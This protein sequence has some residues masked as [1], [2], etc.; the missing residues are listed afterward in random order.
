MKT[1]RIV[2]AL[3]I[4][5]T[6]A[7]A[8]TRDRDARGDAHVRDGSGREAKR[9]GGVRQDDL[10]DGAR[11]RFRARDANGREVVREGVVSS[12]R[13]RAGRTAIVTDGGHHWEF[14]EGGRCY[15]PWSPPDLPIYAIVET[16]VY[17]GPPTRLEMYMGI[18]AMLGL[19]VGLLVAASGSNRP[20]V[21][22]CDV[23]DPNHPCSST[24]SSGG[25]EIAAIAF[26]LLGI[27]LGGLIGLSN[28][29]ESAW[30]PIRMA[31][32][33]KRGEQSFLTLSARF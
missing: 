8:Q 1:L 24:P 13:T 12:G 10:A 11:V 32:Y 17:V 25:R 28:E 22:D 33:E 29:G 26:P 16:H 9:S 3:L 31:G 23:S 2:L 18:G 4:V 20:A 6:P 5:A 19:G 30:E 27:A 21:I 14:D 7:L 15:P